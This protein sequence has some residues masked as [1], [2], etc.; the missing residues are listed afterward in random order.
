MGTRTRTFWAGA[1]IALGLLG[2]V[3]GCGPRQDAAAP[4]A[5]TPLIARADLFG[6][7]VRHGAQLSP[8]GDR[9]AFLAARDGVANLWVLPVGAMDEARAVTDDRGRGVRSFAWGPDSSTLLYAVDAAGDGNTQLFAVS[10]D[11]GEPRPLTPAGARAEIVG[12]SLADPDGV[13]ITLN[14]RDAAWPDLV[15]VDLATGS[16][17]LV[18]RNGATAATRFTRFVLDRENRLRLALRTQANGSVDVLTRSAEGGWSILFTTPF[19]DVPLSAPLAFEANG[20]SFLMLDSAGRDRAVLMR[21]DAT[22]GVKAVLGESARADVADVWLDPATNAPEA[23]AANYLRSEWRALD[24]DA[25]SDLEFLD[26]QLTGDFR[27]TSR[28][29]D[30]GRW[31]VVEE[32][33]QTATRTHVYDRVDRNN[34]RISLLFRHRP[35][36]DSAP[37]QPMT[38]IEI[39][40]RDGLTLVSYLTLPIGAD[41]NGDGRP[42]T[43]VPLVLVPHDG[44]WARDS[45][46]FN[47][48]HQ[49]LAN[50]GYAVLSVNFRGSTGF[51]EA[52]VTAGNREW[53]GRIQEDLQDALQWAIDNGVAQSDRIAIIGAGFGGYTAIAGLTFTPELFRCAV[54]YGAPTNLSRLVEAAPPSL[55]DTWYL[56]VGDTRTVEG[57]QAL[58]GRSP[59]PRVGQIRKPLLIGVGSLDRVGSRAEFDQIALSLRR[60]SI[61]LTSIVFPDEGGDF[62]R[63]QNRLAF[64]AVAEQFLSDCLGGRVEPVGAAFEGANM[65]VFDGATTAPGLQA[66]QR[67]P[68]SVQPTSDVRTPVSADG[69]AVAPHMSDAEDD[70][71]RPAAAPPSN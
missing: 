19:D 17:T 9:V 45:Y 41:T 64:A 68:A 40:A 57:R 30:D 67:R 39:E 51:G 15:R 70:D 38:P 37:L 8:R 21:V 5:A 10:A 27:V 48:M 24:L 22:S 16:R 4:A 14:Q 46:G 29:A 13:V 34:R 32:G 44:P 56:R 54:A 52:F 12:V 35:G 60:R 11:G 36:L 33:P 66:F 25:Q 43:P 3:A 63:P 55:R 49:W 23:F 18:Q 58:R 31:I 6:E 42:E 26:A 53:G 28:S 61:P 62:V 59:A 71:P 69:V 50:R 47:P 2:A 20:N 7:A 65:Q 1:A